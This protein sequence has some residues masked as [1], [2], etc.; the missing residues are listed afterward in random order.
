MPDSSS[1]RNPV[2][3][4]AEDFVERFRRGEHPSLT[5]YTARHPELAEEIRDLFPALVMME[6]IRPDAEDQ[7][8]EQETVAGGKT[9]ERLGDF[10]ILREVGRGGM[11]IVYEAEQESLGR[12]VAL[13]VLPSTSLLDP[14]RLGR[15]LREARSAARLHHTNIVPV[16]GVGE[17]DGLHYYVMQFIHGQGLDQVL[18][19]LKRLRRSKG[20]ATEPQGPQTITGPAQEMAQALITGDFRRIEGGTG[21]ELPQSTDETR[22]LSASPKVLESEEP[23]RFTMLAGARSADSLTVSSSTIHLPGQSHT[24]LT[25]SG[26]QYWQSVA[27]IGIQVADALAYAHAQ[28]TLHRDI[29]PSNLLLDTQGTVWV[30]DFGLAKALTEQDN[31]THTG[32]I[33]GTLRYMAPER[34]KGESDAR[35]DIYSLGLTLYELLTLRPAFREV[36]RNK[37]IEL[38]L[39]DEPT[40]PR[41]LNSAVPRDLETIVLKAIAREP[42]LRYSGAADMAADLRRFVEDKPIQAR[43]VSTRERFVR[44]C[45]RNPALASLLAT[46]QAALIGMVALAWWSNA[47]INDALEEKEQERT[48][49][50]AAGRSADEAQRRA[51]KSRDA[52]LAETYRALLSETRAH[53]LAHQSGWRYEALQRLQKLSALDTP[54]RDVAELR[55]EAVACI[56]EFDAFEMAR[57]E[58]HGE[59]VWSLDFSRDGGT[60]A[61]AG[62][63][64]TT[65]LWDVNEAR[66]IRLINDPFALINQ[67]HTSLSPLPAVRFH[68]DGR[69]LGYASWTRQVGLVAWEGRVPGERIQGK[70]PPRYLSFDQA[71]KLLAVSWGDG[72]VAL[73]EADSGKLQ[74]EVQ[75]KPGW[76]FPNA[77]SPDGSLLATTSVE[78]TVDLWALG[79]GAKPA[80]EPVRL[81]RHR[82]PVR[83]LAFSP[84]GQTLGSASADQTARLWDTKGEADPITLIG[85]TAMTSGIAFS[86]DGGLVATTSDDQTVRLWDART[87]QALMTLTPGIGPMLSVAFSPDGTRLA[88]GSGTVVLYQLVSRQNRQRLAGHTY[89]VHGLAFHPNKPVLYSGGADRRLIAWDAQTGRKLRDQFIDRRN[90]I[91]SVAVSPDGALLAVGLSTFFTPSGKDYSVELRDT[92]A[93]EV[94][95]VLPGPTAPLL[96][97]A[98]D[99]SGK[100]LAAVTRDGQALI[101]NVANGEIVHEW[102][103]ELANPIPEVVFLN[104][105]LRLLHAAGNGKLIVRHLPAN[106]V[107]R[108]VPLAGGAT[109]LNSSPDESRLAVGGFDGNIHILSLPDLELKHTI[110]KAHEG[111]I[112]RVVFSPDGR[113]LVSGGFDRK[114]IFWDGRTYQR[115]FTLP[116]TS[117]VYNLAFDRDGLR[118]AIAGVEELITVWNLALVRPELASVNLDWDAPAPKPTSDVAALAALTP[119]PAVKR[120]VGPPRPTSPTAAPTATGPRVELDNLLKLGRFEEVIAGAEKLHANNREDKDILVPWGESLFSLGR[121]A[122]SVEVARKHLDLCPDCTWAL[123]QL[124]E[125]H[126]ALDAPEEAIKH[127]ERLIE[128]HPS[129]APGP[130]LLALI[131][132]HGPKAARDPEK[133]L[134]LAQKAVTLDPA[135]P[136]HQATLGL[137]YYRLGK[138]E[139]AAETLQPLLAK[140]Q[141]RPSGHLVLAMSCQQLGKK[142]QAAEIY[143]RAPHWWQEAALH[144][145]A[146]QNLEALRA[147]AAGVLGIDYSEAA[148]LREL[149]ANDL[150]ARARA[151]ARLRQD[152]PA[153]ADLARV[154]EQRPEDVDL[155]R[156]LGQLQARLKRWNGVADT[157]CKIL[158]LLPEERNTF[159]KRAQACNELVGWPEAFA[160]L[161]EM[162]PK[163][164]QPWVAKARSHVLRNQ[165]DEA[166]KA[167]ERVIDQ[168]PLSSDWFEYA[169]LL[170]VKGDEEGYRTFV[171]RMIERAGDKPDEYTQF[172]LSRVCTL[173][174]KPPVEWSRVVAWAETAHAQGPAFTHYDH[175]L[176]AAYVR[177]G[178]FDKALERLSKQ[179]HRTWPGVASEWL[180]LAILHHHQGRPDDARQWFGKAAQQIDQRTREAPGQAV[181]QVVAQVVAQAVALQPTDWLEMLILRREVERLL[182]VK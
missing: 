113:L 66:H 50:L 145:R 87:G 118:L 70:A 84:N 176:S 103:A 31:L 63:D 132:A 79:E 51:L 125:S 19:E 168:R 16:Y 135:N 131:R 165:W 181:A 149:S 162:R 99:P 60:L 76:Y 141:L 24:T 39:H 42:G 111:R 93:G 26:R 107:I 108:E 109:T 88:A 9:L 154:L 44:W 49:A 92:E 54:Q 180:F 171:Q 98:F 8:G 179:A 35:G 64:G 71:G 177:A 5:E 48:A 123:Y 150:L 97:I 58:G 117:P 32:D 47:R 67:R 147:E 73:H 34:F 105:G 20:P 61:T 11:G 128:R 144:P 95:R 22:S 161:L 172:L 114:V 52:A 140:N 62:Y 148:T 69:Y 157:Y 174:P 30:T 178:Q 25:E 94:R 90:P 170:L 77:L 136:S 106:E 23:D 104:K 152:E 43:R 122:E 110:E 57:F 4:L 166:A 33:V 7:T 59:G 119:A 167:Y 10:R 173:T 74:N 100:R 158:D 45:R 46:V 53:R 151:H 156:E 72:R 89:A 164:T 115:L 160:K 143:R 85:H 153:L 83:G 139:Q 86:P 56:G 159:H 124:G 91:E 65:R 36:D 182:Q 38:L 80:S 6:D 169:A 96:G 142:E 82:A 27:R 40:P 146:V 101:W 14:A 3:K 102:K 15:F 55:G 41:K 21:A 129:R 120:V 12:H 126:F 137:V 29:K 130:A 2:E 13:K 138:F 1:D 116:Q 127:L 81:G 163:E 133:A 18:S 37:L 75:V 155:L 175:A 68:P 112:N 78:N 17:S 134:P 28:G 121:Y